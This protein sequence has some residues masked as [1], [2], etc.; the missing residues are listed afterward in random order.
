VLTSGNALF[1]DL[2][3]LT[4]DPLPAEVESLEI[5]YLSPADGHVYTLASGIDP[6]LTHAR[7]GALGP[8]QPFAG[9]TYTFWLVAV[10]PGGSTPSDPITIDTS[11]GSLGL[12]ATPTSPTSAQLT[13]ATYDD[14]IPVYDL[15]YSTDGVT[16]TQ[17]TTTTATALTLTN[18][19]PDTNYWFK[20]R[21]LEGGGS[22]S[23]AD[24][25]TLHTAST[26]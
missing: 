22:T 10:G 17:Y 25:V 26:G 1:P 15:W 4:W 13:W 18:L 14:T 23:F 9:L 8:D 19:Q 11:T 3:E 20:L 7:I 24:P 6:S 5:D 12:V 2:V 16:Y 21:V